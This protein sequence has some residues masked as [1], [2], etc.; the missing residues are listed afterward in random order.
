MKKRASTGRGE[1]KIRQIFRLT[2]LGKRN[3]L[4][5]DESDGSFGKQRASH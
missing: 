5:L 2:L 4:K 1:N 3:I